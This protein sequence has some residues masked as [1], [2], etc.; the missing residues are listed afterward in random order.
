MSK[1]F[2]NKCGKEI[3]VD[4]NFCSSCGSNLKKTGKNNIKKNFSYFNLISVLLFLALAVIFYLGLTE[5]K[6]NKSTSQPKNDPHAGMTNSNVIETIKTLEEH[7][8]NDP[9]NEQFTL[10]LANTLQ[11]A[12]F[13]PR[14]IE[15][16]KKY[17]KINSK[18]ADAFVDLGICYFESGSS[19]LAIA[20]MKNAIKV[21]KKHQMAYFNL[22]IVNLNLGNLEESEKNFKKAISVNPGNEVSAKAKEFINQHLEQKNN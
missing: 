20:E 12:K 19:E 7:L 21:N 13:F 6:T 2:C 1:K 14:A 18:N 10:I 5:N 17:L 11:D 8:K 3:N 15:M 22:G 16:Y 4:S 9:N